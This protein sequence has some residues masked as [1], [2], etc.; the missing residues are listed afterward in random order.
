M[1]ARAL[2]LSL[3]L[4]TLGG[5][6]AAPDLTTLTQ[7]LQKLDPAAQAESIA[8]S[9][10][11]GLYEITSGT[12]VFYTNDSGRYILYGHLL[13]LKDNQPQSLTEKT[14]KKLR[15][16][17]IKHLDPKTL[18]T[19]SPKKPLYTLTVFTD[20]DCAYCRKLHQEMPQLNKLG[21]A[22]R[23]ASFPRAGIG[24][25]SYNKAV[26]VWCAR[27]KQQALTDAK[28]GKEVSKDANCHSEGLINKHLKLVHELDVR[29][30]PVMFL[31]DGTEIP[32]YVPAQTLLA[33]LENNA[34]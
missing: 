10:L 5:T 8:D 23:Y 2:L 1:L 12:H 18:I 27:D 14:V 28:Q 30:T 6:H 11:P 3:A 34:A 7:Q 22:V 9:P 29:A 33:R 26:A 17:A 15:A 4:L 25:E 21:I 13:D 32:G 20:I 31:E 16:K 19:F 24:S